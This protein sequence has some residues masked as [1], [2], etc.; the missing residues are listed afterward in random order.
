MKQLKCK[1]EIFNEIGSKAT[2]LLTGVTLTSL[3]LSLLLSSDESGAIFSLIR[4][5]APS[6][7]NRIYKDVNIV[8]I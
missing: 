3:D 4:M 7:I 2:D 5:H 6:L 8:K 1:A